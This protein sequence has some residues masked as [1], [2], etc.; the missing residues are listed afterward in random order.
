VCNYLRF[1]LCVGFSFYAGVGYTQTPAPD[2][3]RPLG[4][5]QTAGESTNNAGE[6]SI[7]LNSILFGNERKIAI[8]NGQQ[9]REGDI[10]KG[11]GARVKKIEPDA[12]TLQQSKKIWRVPLNT[13]I[14]R[15]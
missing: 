4:Y 12:V 5:E 15:K 2:P 14:I 3:T 8:I 9:L 7:R 11:I 10:I 13:R 1:A 6:T